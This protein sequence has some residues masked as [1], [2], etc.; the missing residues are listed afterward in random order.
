M[1]YGQG[2]GGCFLIRGV[3]S[4]QQAWRRAAKENERTHSNPVPE[5]TLAAPPVARRSDVLIL[6]LRKAAAAVVRLSSTSLM[7]PSPS[8]PGENE[9]KPGDR[10]KQQTSEQSMDLRNAE[11][12]GCDKAQAARDTGL[13]SF[14]LLP[15][16]CRS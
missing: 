7:S 6:Q 1:G 2:A 3:Y 13:L 12:A 9:A 15:A 16:A 14:A 5:G 10:V 4:P 11:Y 8:R